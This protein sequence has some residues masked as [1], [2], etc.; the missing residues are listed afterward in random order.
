[1]ETIAL[2]GGTVFLDY[3]V[4]KEGEW[5]HTVNEY[6][7]VDFLRQGS[8]F[9]LPRHGRQND[10]PPH[11]ISHQA[12]MTALKEHGVTS[13]IGVNSTGSL[14]HDIHP[15]S[16][17]IPDDYINLW[18]EQTFFNDTLTH[19][20]PMLDR[21]LRRLLKEAAEHCAIPVIEKGIYIQT[22]GPRLETRAEVRMLSHFAD[23]VGMTLGSEAS[24]ARELSLPYASICS[25]DNYAHGL[26]DAS[27]S[28]DDIRAKARNSAER[29]KTIFLELIKTF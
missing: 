13:I 23:I 8:L 2:L 21:R 26:V 29:I 18:G 16:L 14:K 10:R 19:I 28:A 4:L 20:T 25:V 9:F 7:E 17:V 24:A 11:I 6:G 22:R 3:E 12:H 5:H 27:L 15:G 1:M